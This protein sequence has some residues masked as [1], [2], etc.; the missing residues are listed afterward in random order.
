MKK[1][2]TT[3]A[4]RKESKAFTLI[5]LLVVIAIIAILAAMLLPALSKA[6]DKAIRSQCMSNLHQIGVSLFNYVG[7]NGNNNKLPTFPYVSGTAV[8]PGLG[9]FLGMLET[10]CWIT[11]VATRRCFMIRELRSV[12]QMLSIGQAPPTRPWIIG[13]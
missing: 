8:P 6:K 2:V 9:I 7:D 11:W 13:I 5:E 3:S 12:L 1:T 4:C 10:K